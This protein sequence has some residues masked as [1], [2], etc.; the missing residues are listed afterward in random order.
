MCVGM[1]KQK[2]ARSA[3]PSLGKMMLKTNP[4]FSASAPVLNCEAQ[5]SYFWM[6]YFL[7]VHRASRRIIRSLSIWPYLLIADILARMKKQKWGGKLTGAPLGR[8][9]SGLFTAASLTNPLKS[10]RGSLRGCLMATL[11]LFAVRQLTVSDPFLKGKGA[12]KSTGT[13]RRGAKSELPVEI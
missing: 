6:P 1:Y 12:D 10:E 9:L 5:C 2:H 11:S 13:Q 7:S 4:N 3:K 8:G